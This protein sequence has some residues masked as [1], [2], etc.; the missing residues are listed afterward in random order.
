MVAPQML[1]VIVPDDLSR[2]QP[3]NRRTA[4]LL[5]FSSRTAGNSATSYPG[6]RIGPTLTAVGY[7]D[8]AFQDQKDDEHY[9]HNYDQDQHQPRRGRHPGKFITRPGAEGFF[10]PS[11]HSFVSLSLLVQQVLKLRSYDRIS[12]L[13]YLSLNFLSSACHDRTCLKGNAGA[14][15]CVEAM[16]VLKDQRAIVSLR[17]AVHEPAENN[18][19]LSAPNRVM[20]S[21]NSV[22]I[23]A[24]S[25]PRNQANCAETQVETLR[26]DL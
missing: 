11:G 21:T 18:V 20:L 6:L 24:Q 9:E 13:C 8:A 1:I 2:R 22:E 4:L 10:D 3:R 19:Q 7:S 23:V 14:G 16:T 15:M 17:Q 26:S 12:G 5:G 25:D